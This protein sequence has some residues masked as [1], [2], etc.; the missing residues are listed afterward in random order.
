MNI[1]R[2]R[3][4]ILLQALVMGPFLAVQA[5]CDDDFWDP[6][7][8]AEPD[9]SDD[10]AWNDDVVDAPD[11]R[12]DPDVQADSDAPDEVPTVDCSDPGACSH[13]GTCS[14]AGG[15]VVCDCFQDRYAGERCGDC[16]EGYEWFSDVCA[17]KAQPR[18][19]CDRDYEWYKTQMGTGTFEVENC[20]PTSVSMAMVWYQRALD[21]D[22]GEVRSAVTGSTPGWWYTTDIE[23]AL[24]RY[25]VPYSVKDYQTAEAIAAELDA[26]HVLILCLTMGLISPESPPWNSH[27]N[28][29]YSYD[30]GH[31]VVVKGHMESGAWLDVYDPNSWTEDHYTDGAPYGRDRFYSGTEVLAS[32]RE[33]WPFMFVIGEARNKGLDTSLIPVGR[34]GP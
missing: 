18:A 14:D 31:F 3:G 16:A 12:V 29:F 13:N 10:D 20:G 30:S 6:D 17:L 24:E 34:S 21:I 5:G 22:P 11:D 2:Q 32:A 9:M 15:T 26:G 19:T 33:W 27:F 4:L 28:R 23:S 7:S 8:F 25:G 1:R